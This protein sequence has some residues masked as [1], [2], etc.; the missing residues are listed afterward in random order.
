MDAT[1]ATPPEEVERIVKE[2]G[3]AIIQEM[4]D[5]LHVEYGLKVYEVKTA[6]IVPESL[7]PGAGAILELASHARSLA[8][9]L[10]K[11]GIVGY[12]VPQVE[13]SYPRK[14]LENSCSFYFKF[15][16][17]EGAQFGWTCS[18]TG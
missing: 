6:S 12:L 15:T 9:V 17:G 10:Y 3:D 13:I 8:A 1:V 7:I 11:Y 18:S 14:F 4:T 16:S 5:V 2:S